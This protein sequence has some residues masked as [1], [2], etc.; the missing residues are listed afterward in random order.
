VSSKDGV[1]RHTKT[2]FPG[3]Q[4]DDDRDDEDKKERE[5]KRGR[6]RKHA[7]KEPS[8]EKKGRGRPKKEKPVG[9]NAPKIHDPFGRVKPGAEKKGE[10]GSKVKGKAMSGSLEEKAAS[11][12]QQ[13]FMGMVHAAQK[14]GKPASAEVAKVAKSMGKKD[15]RDFAATK[16]KGLPQHVA[17]SVNFK[18]MMEETNMTLDEM[19]ESLSADIM[20]YKKSGACSETLRD[21]MEV[22]AHAK[23]QQ[24]SD[25]ID[26]TNPQ[27]YD[28]P[29]V[30]RK[31]QGLP[32]L[33]M[34]DVKAKD[35]K[36]QMDFQKRVG[37]IPS[38]DDDLN[39]LA[40]LAG[41]STESK[42]AKPD[43]LDMDKDG[44]K[45]EPMK[46]AVADKAKETN[47]GWSA[48]R[49]AAA[50]QKGS[51]GGQVDETDMEEGNEFSG[52]LA[53]AR[54]TGAK[55]F[56]VDG[57]TYPVKENVEVDECGE[58]PAT[59][60]RDNINISSNYSAANG[61]KTLSVTA[62]GEAAEALAQLLKL[63]GMLRAGDENIEEAD[64]TVA[65]PE[66]QV[67]SPRPKYAS[68]KTIT[69][70]GDDL[71]REKTQDPATANRA[72]NPFTNEDKL[73]LED[74]LA[75]EYE[76]IKKKS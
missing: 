12:A 23:K 41:L 65:E 13:K 53:K 9:H 70:Q 61:E 76:S 50:K 27:D 74:R 59:G 25:G 4:S 73:T 22:Y 48:E 63:S 2:D 6:P 69:T 5:G 3:Y 55:E 54:A 36:A 14:G 17:E 37:N 43:F 42:N 66:E 34:Q 68:I 11:Q 7:K 10:K 39:E 44:N 29:A 21:F 71:N 60:Q 38:A 40:K 75:A 67:Q 15:A 24:L 19:L 46:K 31:Q 8:A 64:V 72:A 35:Q 28:I 1:T 33:T 18:R 45:T 49:I 16:H 30:F 58:M 32:P 26:T 51:W 62:E 52:E 20:E 56:D 47:Q 57:K